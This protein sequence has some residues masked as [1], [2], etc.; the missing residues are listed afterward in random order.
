MYLIVYYFLLLLFFMSQ[1]YLVRARLEGDAEMKLSMDV[2]KHD[3]ATQ[4]FL[5]CGRARKKTTSSSVATT[6]SDAIYSDEKLDRFLPGSS[7]QCAAEVVCWSLDSKRVCVLITRGIRETDGGIAAPPIL[8]TMSYGDPS[9]VESVVPVLGP[10]EWNW[11]K[12]EGSKWAIVD[13]PT[14]LCLGGKDVAVSFSRLKG[15]DGPWTI[16][17]ADSNLTRIGLPMND[18]EQPLKHFRKETHATM[19]E[20]DDGQ[21]LVC[22]SKMDKVGVGLPRIP[23][24]PW[25][26]VTLQEKQS[27]TWKPWQIPAQGATAL[28]YCPFSNGRILY[29]AVETRLMI[30]GDGLLLSVISLPAAVKNILPLPSERSSSTSGLALLLADESRTSIIVPLPLPLMVS[31]SDVCLKSGD[32]IDSP[33]PSPQGYWTPYLGVGAIVAGDFDRSGRWKLAML[34]VPLDAPWKLILKNTVIQSVSVLSCIL[35]YDQESRA[36]FPFERIV[37]LPRAEKSKGGDGEGMKKRKR[38]I[39]VEGKKGGESGGLDENQTLEQLQGLNKVLLR[40]LLMEEEQL[41]RDKLIHRFRKSLLK[42]CQGTILKLTENDGYEGGNI[43][44]CSCN[45]QRDLKVSYEAI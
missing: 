25:F 39:E 18:G 29:M 12:V 11:E 6:V 40:R 22:Y 2:A 8:A 14:L 10:K 41:E 1:G 19:L 35:G 26:E 28:A 21:V 44:A 32:G 43:E 38:R 23:H 20:N 42:T 5:H 15:G 4:R 36:G 31:L 37:E 27:P 33:H 34:P 16:K 24:F 13:G 45:S 3:A 30:I 9:T 7:I 17:I